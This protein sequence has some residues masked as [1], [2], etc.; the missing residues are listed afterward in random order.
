MNELDIYFGDLTP[1]AQAEFLEFKHLSEPSE[2]N[3]DVFPIT[4][5]TSDKRIEE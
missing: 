3:Y 2:G 1:D 5:L 4:T